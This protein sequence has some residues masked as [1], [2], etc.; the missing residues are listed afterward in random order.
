MPI[1]K[2]ALLLISIAAL[3]SISIARG[4]TSA[5][6]AANKWDGW[7]SDEKCG[8]K[9]ADPSHAACA[10]KCVTGGAAIVFI[11]GK[12]KTIYKVDNQ[13]ALKDHVGHYVNIE[14]TLTGDSLHV[15]KVTMLKQP[16]PGDQKGEHGSGH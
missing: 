2:V 5:P 14:G 4:R 15:D 3:A 16:K 9:G 12:D 8:A 10:T 11:A 6:T 1:K 7:V 13:D